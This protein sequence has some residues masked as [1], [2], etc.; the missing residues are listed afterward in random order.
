M[1]NYA[2]SDQ[3]N[4]SS[5]SQPAEAL[6]SEE[7]AQSYADI[8]AWLDLHPGF[9]QGLAWEGGSPPEKNLFAFAHPGSTGDTAVSSTVFGQSPGITSID[10]HALQ[11]LRGINEGYTSLGVI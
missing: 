11:P 8:A 2:P 1:Q 10:G 3:T 6:T 9:D 7:I 5:P 4:D